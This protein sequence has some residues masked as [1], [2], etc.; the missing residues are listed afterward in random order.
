[1]W[2]SFNKVWGFKS[3]VAY[4]SEGI[5]RLCLGMR[6]KEYR[7]LKTFADRTCVYTVDFL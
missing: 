1:V 4:L 2:A 5:P 6:R 3:S 7:K